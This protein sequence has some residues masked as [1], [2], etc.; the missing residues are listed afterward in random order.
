M[1]RSEYEVFQTMIIWLRGSDAEDARFLYPHIRWNQII[2]FEFQLCLNKAIY[3]DYEDMADLIYKHIQSRKP[4]FG[5]SLDECGICTM[6]QAPHP[7]SARS[8]TIFLTRKSFIEKDKKYTSNCFEAMHGLFQWRIAVIRREHENNVGAV[9]KMRTLGR[10]NPFSHLKK[11]TDGSSIP[12]Q[13]YQ[14]HNSLTRVE[15]CSTPRAVPLEDIVRRTAKEPHALKTFA[16]MLASRGFKSAESENSTITID[17][18]IYLGPTAESRRFWFVHS[19][20]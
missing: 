8:L 9:M 19:L 14:V 18:T 10:N 6:H 20:R 1:R 16:L 15:K 3:M 17:A 12:V 7:R 11:L 4:E 13:L 5:G 2:F